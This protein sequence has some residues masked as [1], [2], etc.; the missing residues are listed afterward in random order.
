MLVS[1]ILMTAIALTSLISLFVPI[2]YEIYR[3]IV[4]LAAVIFGI[5]NL[6]CTGGNS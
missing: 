5:Y 1:S 3:C 6:S 4:S 2:P